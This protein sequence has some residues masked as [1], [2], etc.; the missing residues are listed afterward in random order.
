MRILVTG[1]NG[2]LGT[3]VC[4]KLKD[5][6]DVVGIGTLK[7]ESIVGIEY[8]RAYIESSTFVSEMTE[9]VKNCDVIIHLAAYIDKDNFNDKL[10]DVN[11]K[12]TAHLVKLAKELNAKKII[13]SSGLTVIGEPVNLPITEEHRT[14]PNTLYHITK[15]MSEKIVNLGSTYNIKP[16]NLRIPSPIGVGMNENTILPMI[17]KRCLEN[18]P[19]VILG[20]GSRRQNYIDVRDVAEAIVSSVDKDIEGVYNIA[21]ETTISN[22]EL[23]KLCIDLTGSSSEIVFSEKEDP[24][25]SKYWDASIEKAKD[26]L[27]F[28]PKYSLENTINDIIHHFRREGNQ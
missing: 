10:I 1:L 18:K 20:K 25:E 17:L 11:C 12:G 21:S 16:I 6:H 4:N 26:V 2:F 24:E 7:R 5:K 28:K 19:I 15:L 27:F 13:H 9:K 23:A 3:Y 14:D 22:V 8:F